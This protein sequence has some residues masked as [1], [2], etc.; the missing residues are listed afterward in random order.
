MS[1]TAV[2]ESLASILSLVAAVFIFDQYLVRPRPYKLL[3]ALGLLFYGLAAGA[4]AAGTLSH[5]TVLDYKAWYYFG[6]VLTAAYL[7]LG[8]LFL[9]A[10]RRWAWIVAGIIGAVSLYTAVR[11]LMLPVG[12]ETTARLASLPTLAVTDVKQ[13]SI[14][15]LDVRILT[16][17]AMNIPGSLLLFGGAVWSAW[18][19]L[20][21]HSAAYRVISMVLLALGAVFPAVGSG[22][23]PLGYSGMAALGEFLGAI[24]ILSGLLISLDVFTVFRIPF[25]HVVLHQRQIHAEAVRG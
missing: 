22:L 6:G 2:F 11:V 7:G 10:P 4:D 25:T 12:A 24:C 18:V 8:S 17:A 21:K 13:F 3:W 20:R 9:L 1:A 23:Q 5:W 19:Y 16:V 15:P 14:M